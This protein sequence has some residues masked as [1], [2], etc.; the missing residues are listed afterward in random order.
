[1]QEEE[2]LI[3]AHPI[4]IFL[5][6]K[7][8]KASFLSR[9]VLYSYNVASGEL[10]HHFN[11]HEIN[12][13]S[14]RAIV[15]PEKGTSTESFLIQHP[16]IKAFRI[17]PI[18]QITIGING[19]LC[20]PVEVYSLD[21]SDSNITYVEYL[22]VVLRFNESLQLV[23]AYSFEL[24]GIP[25]NT[26]LSIAFG[27]YFSGERL[28]T[29][30]VLTKNHDYVHVGEF[31]LNGT[32]YDFKHALGSDSIERIRHFRELNDSNCLVSLI[33]GRIGI[34]NAKSW[35]IEKL[36]LADDLIAQSLSKFNDTIV[37]VGRSKTTNNIVI[38]W[39]D[40]TLNQIEEVKF[41][42]YIFENKSIVS[43]A[44][45]RD[46]LYLMMVDPEENYWSFLIDIRPNNLKHILPET[47]TD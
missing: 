33:K 5:D 1:M 12:A 20:V 19:D 41:P 24:N 44:L 39:Y 45:L 3:G 21:L 10:I 32:K 7:V 31:E 35:K 30:L 22:P 25:H 18:T 40:N 46:Q 14:L 27:N 8:E 17:S 13:D 47:L 11:L 2:V 9:D 37:C 16:E 42:F 6:D 28:Y 36:S 34:V 38:R 15:Y 4:N 29:N 23:A 26:S 43:S